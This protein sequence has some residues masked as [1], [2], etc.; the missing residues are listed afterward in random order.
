MLSPNL[1]H[2]RIVLHILSACIWIGGQ[3]TLAVV[4]PVLRKHTDR[5]AT[6]AV[7]QQFQ[8]VAWPAFAVLVITGIWNIAEI[9]VGD[10]SSADLVTLF[11]KLFVVAISGVGAAVHALALGPSIAHAADE[12][13]ERRRRAR[14]GAAAGLG[15]LFAVVAAVLGVMLGR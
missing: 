14:S 10:Q 5:N 15:L 7:A 2:L 12:A 4:V 9:D 8:R 1:T 11:V 13:A 6:R 3:F